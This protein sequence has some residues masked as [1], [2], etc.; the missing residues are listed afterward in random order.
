[1]SLSVRDRLLGSLEDLEPILMENV[2]DEVLIA[3]PVKSR[4]AEIQR[5]IED[6]ERAGVQS[7]YS[8]QLFPSRLARPH[9]E[10]PNGQPAVA[11]KVVSDD[12]RLAVKRGLDIAVAAIG[13]VLLSPLL[14]GLWIGIHATSKGP[15]IFGQERYGWRKRRFTMYKFRTMVVDAEAQQPA[16]EDRNE[17]NGPVFKLSDDPRV[18]PLGRML[19]RT[20]LDE[21]PQLWNVLR[22]EMSLVGPRPLPVRDVN[23]FETA[24]IMRRFSVLPGLTGLWQVSGRSELPFEDWI[25]LDLEYIDR[26]SLGLDLR[27]LVKTIPAVIGARGAK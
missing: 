14:G 10:T 8:P 22:G 12:Y 16:L 23:R 5:A 19:R 17:A 24:S 6:C 7:R 26:W 2:V 27:L 25:R 9:L 4:Y 3:L 18:T 13:L 1:M 20:S 11:M 21:L 15:A